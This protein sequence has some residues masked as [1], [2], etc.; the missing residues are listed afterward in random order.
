MRQGSGV[1]SPDLSVYQGHEH[2]IL[3]SVPSGPVWVS[4]LGAPIPS[5]STTGTL[6][7]GWALVFLLCLGLLPLVWELVGRAWADFQLPEPSSETAK[8]SCP[9]SMSR[10]GQE[11]ALGSPAVSGATQ[12]VKS[13]DHWVKGARGIILGTHLEGLSFLLGPGYRHLPWGRW[14]R[15]APEYPLGLGVKK[16]K[17]AALD[18]LLTRTPVLAPQPAPTVS[19]EQWGPHSLSGSW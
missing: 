5:P 19:R 18:F 10:V 15:A 3:S 6:A 11:R 13:R 1:H 17:L 2:R 12:K 14:G 9:R 16:R 8:Q 7:H 4:F